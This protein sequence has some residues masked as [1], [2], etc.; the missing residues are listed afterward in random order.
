[1]ATLTTKILIKAGI[2]P[3]NIAIISPYAAQVQLIAKLVGPTVSVRTVDGYQGG[4]AEVVILSLVRSNIDGTTGFLSDRRRLNVAVSRARKSCIVIGDSGTVTRD[5]FIEKM[6]EYFGENANLISPAQ[7]QERVIFLLNF[8]F[9]INFTLEKAC[10]EY[11]SISEQAG[12]SATN[13]LPLHSHTTKIA[14]QAPD[15][16]KRPKKPAQPKNDPKPKNINS[17][18]SKL[19]KRLEK[20]VQEAQAKPTVSEIIANNI[21]QS[22]QILSKPFT[23]LKI[24]EPEQ[25]KCPDCNK[26]MPV[27][28]LE[29][30]QIHCARLR[31]ERP[32]P[33][34][35][36][37]TKK[38]QM[39]KQKKI[40]QREESKR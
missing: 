19:E 40:H 4:E 37:K 22:S 18:K 21:K 12:Y 9:Q 26:N 30:H 16:P 35:N 14:S 23:E 24:E 38:D 10:E 13:K 29:L 32:K 25:G 1:M 6:F 34:E 2:K 31:R 39:K 33:V 17:S 7:F 5:S 20:Q 15:E 3:K 28:N 36:D 27:S 8:I 11:E